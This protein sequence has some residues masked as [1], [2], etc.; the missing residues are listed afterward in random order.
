MS[1]SGVAIIKET[2]RFNTLMDFLACTNYP[3]YHA[4]RLHTYKN[5]P[6]KMDPDVAKRTKYS[7][8]EFSQR[9]SAMGGNTVSQ[10]IQ[11]RKGQKSSTTTRSIFA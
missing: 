3:R 1:V 8:Q 9:N 10:G 7:I 11:Y 2:V 4:D 5:F 6:N